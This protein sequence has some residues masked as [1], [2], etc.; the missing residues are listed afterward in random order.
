MEILVLLL[1]LTAL[2][3]GGIGIF[4]IAD[5]PLMACIG[6]VCLAVAALLPGLPL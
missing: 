4:R 5:R 2:I 6:V 3:V 1:V